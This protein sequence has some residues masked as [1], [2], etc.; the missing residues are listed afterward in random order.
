MQV[1]GIT[2]FAVLWGRDGVAQAFVASQQQ[3]HGL[4]HH[5]MSA[6]C[7]WRGNAA[8]LAFLPTHTQA[9]V[10]TPVVLLEQRQ[11]A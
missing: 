4:L 10:S 8:V 7:V 5:P 6:R 11:T 9:T 3:K 1:M 2:R